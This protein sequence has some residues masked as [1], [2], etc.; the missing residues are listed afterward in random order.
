MSCEVLVLSMMGGFFCACPGVV[1]V[2]C[3]AVFLAV[4]V[5]IGVVLLVAVNI[6][7]LY[8]I[9][10]PVRIFA[11]GQGFHKVLFVTPSGRALVRCKLF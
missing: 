10:G 7:N 11:P 5:M 2:L 8:P 6:F 4:V 3:I 1:D 9:N